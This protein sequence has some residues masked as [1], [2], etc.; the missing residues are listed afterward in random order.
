VRGNVKCH[1]LASNLGKR[2]NSEET[3]G[4]SESC[5]PVKM[6]RDNTQRNEN[7]EHIKI[8]AEHEEL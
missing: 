4:E 6:M 7:K 2:N 8:C 1:G 3:K 5:I